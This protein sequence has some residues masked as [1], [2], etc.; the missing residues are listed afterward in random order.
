MVPRPVA[1][2]PFDVV[3]PAIAIA[4]RGGGA[5]VRACRL[6]NSDRRDANDPDGC[7]AIDHRAV[8]ELAERV[9]SPAEHLTRGRSRAAVDGARGHGREAALDVDAYRLGAIAGPGRQLSVVVS[10]QRRESAV[11]VTAHVCWL[12]A[13]TDTKRAMW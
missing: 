6:Y 8:A 7:R 3:A 5:R 13:A 12:P 1:Q 9:S 10:P 4:C 2:L 11:V